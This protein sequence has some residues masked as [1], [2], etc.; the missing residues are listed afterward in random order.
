MSKKY[1]INIK[2]IKI[3]LKKIEIISSSHDQNKKAQK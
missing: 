1:N 2:K 3:Y